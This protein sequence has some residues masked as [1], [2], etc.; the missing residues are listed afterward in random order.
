MNGM[1]REDFYRIL[2]DLTQKREEK[3]YLWLK[4]LLLLAT[5]SLSVLVSLR[6]G[7][8]NT[9]TAH[10]FLS[11]ALAALGL[12]ILF[13]AISLHGEVRL[14]HETLEQTKK[15]LIRQFEN[16]ETLAE[17]AFCKLPAV[18]TVAETLC[19]TALVVAVI[20]LV[21]YAICN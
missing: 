13:G 2:V 17:P 10:V 8:T 15:E 12:G 5:G 1:R 6:A 7:T 19:Y 18:Y 16:P 11:V 20:S 14:S 4:Q 3:R 9:H 21:I